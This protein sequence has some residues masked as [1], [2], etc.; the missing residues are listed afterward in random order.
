MTAPNDDL[1]SAVLE[2]DV[3]RVRHA[4]GAAGAPVDIRDNE[5][6]STPLEWARFGEE[7]KQNP[8]GDYA[9]TIAALSS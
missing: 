4:L 7:T 9:A 1:V 8:A 2:Q 6:H 5:H 3:D